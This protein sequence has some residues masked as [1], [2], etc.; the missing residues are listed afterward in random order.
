MVLLLGGHSKRFVQTH[1]KLITHYNIKLIY[2]LHKFDCH[3]CW[4]FTV[5]KNTFFCL[6]SNIFLLKMF[7]NFNI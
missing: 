1:F 2:I 6:N 4:N 5:E 7:Q 3:S